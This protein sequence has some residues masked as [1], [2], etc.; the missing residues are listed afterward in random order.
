MEEGDARSGKEGGRLIGAPAGLDYNPSEGIWDVTEGV[1]EAGEVEG[2]ES[3][4]VG[5]RDDDDGTGILEAVPPALLAL[6]AIYDVVG[7]HDLGRIGVGP[8]SDPDA[9]AADDHVALRRIGGVVSKREGR[10]MM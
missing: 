6:D 2:L 8:G 10:R 5:G 1:D 9:V 7:A 4:G 3:A